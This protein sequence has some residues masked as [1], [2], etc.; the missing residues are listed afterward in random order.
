[1]SAATQEKVTL[2][3]VRERGK[4]RIRFHSYTN[5]EGKCYT[6]VY[7][8]NYNCQFPKD[9]RN[10]GWFYEIGR[11]DLVLV[12]GVGKQPFYRVKKNNIKV[13][14]NS[15]P[16]ATEVHPDPSSVSSLITPVMN[17]QQPKKPE[18]VFEVSECV[19]CLEGIP[20]QIFIPCAHLCTCEG[21]YQQLKKAKPSCPLCRRT[22]VSA[23][24]NEP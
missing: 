3:C 5:A 22:V 2:Q 13:L 11:E 23:I 20:N 17:R 1:M 14:R 18:Q 6:N 24:L 16:N 8:N 15:G 9:I 21:C 10:E 19:I 12:P 7:N 4:L